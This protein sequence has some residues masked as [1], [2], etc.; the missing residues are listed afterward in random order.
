MIRA[1][2]RQ[3]GRHVGSKVIAKVVPWSL[4]QR[5][6]VSIHPEWDFVIDREG[7]PA[8]GDYKGTLY[9]FCVQIGPLMIKRHTYDTEE[10]YLAAMRVAAQAARRKHVNAVA[11]AEAAAINTAARAGD[12]GQLFG[13]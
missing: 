1:Q 4:Q 11:R 5:F 7:V 6:D 12:T 10:E 3:W 8:E 2:L 13:E 9:R